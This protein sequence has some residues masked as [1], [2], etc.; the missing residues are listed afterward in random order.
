[1]QF[2]Y[3]ITKNVSVTY[4]FMYRRSL[5]IQSHARIYEIQITNTINAG[6]V[7]CVNCVD[8]LNCV[9]CPSGQYLESQLDKSI[10]PVVTS[11]KV[12]VKSTFDT[13][14]ELKCV[15]CP[16]GTVINGR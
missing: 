9:P 4:S 11:S 1:M 8:Q 5:H 16:A 3:E 13:H 7:K 14:T 15:Q 2:R 10:S 12:S 6:A